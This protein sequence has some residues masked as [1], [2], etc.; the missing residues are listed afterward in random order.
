MLTFTFA[1]IPEFNCDIITSTG[2]NFAIRTLG[3]FT[4]FILMF[5]DVCQLSRFNIPCFSDAPRLKDMG[6]GSHKK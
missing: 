5:S 6:V 4:Q 2:N 1:D 3:N